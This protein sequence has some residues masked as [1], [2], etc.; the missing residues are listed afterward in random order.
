MIFIE[1]IIWSP[2][3]LGQKLLDWVDWPYFFKPFLNG[4]CILEIYSPFLNYT[5]F[6]HN[7]KFYSVLLLSYAFSPLLLD[8]YFIFSLSHQILKNNTRGSFFFFPVPWIHQNSSTLLILELSH[9]TCRRNATKY[10][11]MRQFSW[12]NLEHS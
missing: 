11:N 9:K 7:S 8:T 10:G 1:A 5:N 6:F 3:I 2:F 12:R 4:F